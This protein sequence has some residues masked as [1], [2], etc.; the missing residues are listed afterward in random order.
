MLSVHSETLSIN[1]LLLSVSKLRHIRRGESAD[2]DEGIR[3]VWFEAN[4]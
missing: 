4:K 3:G 2:I 1:V